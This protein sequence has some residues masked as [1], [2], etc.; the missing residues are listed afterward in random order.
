MNKTRLK[1]VYIYLF[2]VAVLLFFGSV[3]FYNNARKTAKKDVYSSLLN[4]DYIYS[5]T[6]INRYSIGGLTRTQA[7]ERASSDMKDLEKYKVALMAYGSDFEKELSFK[8]LGAYYDISD[9]VERGYAL[10]RD[11]SASDR[12]S[13]INSLR[14]RHEYLDPK[15][16]YDPEVLKKKME[17]VKPEMD[18]HISE[19]LYTK[20]DVDKACSDVSEL[21]IKKINGYAVTV[22]GAK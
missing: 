22:G 20:M 10:G 12:I 21:I 9:A 3:V 7:L 19:F 5:G 1:P 16:T 13:A 11:G 2:V 17:E 4:T 15:Y 18:S 14:E 8:E 6:Y